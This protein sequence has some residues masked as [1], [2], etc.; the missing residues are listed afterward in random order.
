MAKG[1]AAGDAGKETSASANTEKPD[2]SWAKCREL[3]LEN[4]EAVVH[5]VMD[6][7][8]FN[9]FTQSKKNRRNINCGGGADDSGD[10]LFGV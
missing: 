8:V 5:N 2:V 9:T 10:L 1:R 7:Y 6:N 3:T 4:K